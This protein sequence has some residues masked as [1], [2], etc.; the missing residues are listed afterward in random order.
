MVRIGDN[1]ALV[2][3]FG[4]QAIGVLDTA[5]CLYRKELLA[6]AIARANHIGVEQYGTS[7]WTKS[8]GELMDELL[9]ELKDAVYYGCLRLAALDGG[10]VPTPVA[11]SD[12]GAKPARHTASTDEPPALGSASASRPDAAL[13]GR[14]ASGAPSR[15][16]GKLREGR[17]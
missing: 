16:P 6:G 8:P 9:D 15:L 13:S 7:S 2:E 10:F 14:V 5:I 11:E 4:E 12:D 17:A 1:T 3:K